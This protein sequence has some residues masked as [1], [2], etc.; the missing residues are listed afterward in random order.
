MEKGKN[1]CI[2]TDGAASNNSLNLIHE[3]SLVTLIHKGTHRSPLSVSAADA[4][5]F[6][7]INGA[8]GLGLDKEIGS[9]E[10]G[11]KADLAI[12]NMK[13]ASMWPANNALAALSYSAN[14]SEVETVIINGA[15]TMEN[16]KI[17]TMDE[18]KIFAENEKTMKRICG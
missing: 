3:M 11:K 7:T 2:G 17:L 10:V 4:F 15:V 6:A 8:K 9:I 1:I 16:R 18:E 12:L 13:T 5:K 14:G